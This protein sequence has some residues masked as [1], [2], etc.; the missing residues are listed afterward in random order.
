MI[1]D[2]VLDTATTAAFKGAQRGWQAGRNA[3]N[4]IPGNAF[5]SKHIAESNEEAHPQAQWRDMAA[6][7]D[8]PPQENA[9]ADEREAMP[10]SHSSPLRPQMDV[11]P[12]SDEHD[13]ADQLEDNEKEAS[14]RLIRRKRH[15][16]TGG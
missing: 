8:N 7:I 16:S 12:L 5:V 14:Q 1:F 10:V 3:N 13:P 9:A 6:G 2:S 11:K 15:I 4:A